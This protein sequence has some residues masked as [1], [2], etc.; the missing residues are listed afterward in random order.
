MSPDEVRVKQ[1]SNALDDAIIR[2]YGYIPRV[3]REQLVRDLCAGVERCQRD[4]DRLLTQR[5]LTE[6]VPVRAVGQA[7]SELRRFKAAS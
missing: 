7:I 3:A 2:I 4:Y 5:T 6:N 1:M